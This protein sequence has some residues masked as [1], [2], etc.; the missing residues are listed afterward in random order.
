MRNYVFF[1]LWL[2]NEKVGKMVERMRAAVSLALHHPGGGWCWG[3][4][5]VVGGSVGGHTLTHLG[6][7]EVQSK[8][9]VA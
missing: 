7:E 5:W 8:T 2:Q 4:W 3:W 6:R 1:L 9:A